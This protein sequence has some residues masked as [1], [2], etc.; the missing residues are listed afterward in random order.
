MGTQERGIGSAD[1]ASTKKPALVRAGLI[2][3]R[4]M[5]ELLAGG[6]AGYA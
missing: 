5:A 3:Q 1:T 4:L 2:A 6:R